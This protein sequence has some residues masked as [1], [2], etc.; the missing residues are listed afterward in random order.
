MWSYF[1]YYCITPGNHYYL[2][3]NGTQSETREGVDLTGVEDQSY[4]GEPGA[5]KLQERTMREWTITEDVAWVDFAGEVDK[6]VGHKPDGHKPAG[7]RAHR[8]RARR[9]RARHRGVTSPPE[10]GQ[11]PAT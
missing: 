6:S 9:T 10:V 3:T 5:L 7:T 1:M 8:S 2:R 11:K 4:L